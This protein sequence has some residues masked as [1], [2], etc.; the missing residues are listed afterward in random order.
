LGF[1]IRAKLEPYLGFLHS[2]AKGKP[3][4]I[5]DFQELYRYLVDDF[6][7]Q[8]CREPEKKDFITKT[9][10]CST[11]RLGKREYLGDSHTSVLLKDLNKC[12]QSK[13]EIPRIRMGSNQEIETLINEEALLFAQYLRNEKLTWIPRIANAFQIGIGRSTSPCVLSLSKKGK[14]EGKLQKMRWFYLTFLS[15]S[16]TSSFFSKT[17]VS[18]KLKESHSIISGSICIFIIASKLPSI[19]M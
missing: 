7:I 10:V 12:F 5:C 15:I 14:K 16:R 8:H 4:L 17:L 11:N 9:E 18:I 1:G 13:V 6:V 3:S 19:T 2:I